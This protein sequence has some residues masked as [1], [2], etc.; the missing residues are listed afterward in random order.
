MISKRFF[1]KSSN[2]K[3]ISFHKTKHQ[4]KLLITIFLQS[5]KN[6]K[7]EK[8]ITIDFNECKK[9]HN[10]FRQKLDFNLIKFAQ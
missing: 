6:K 3:K 9:T 10:F 7:K 8:S 5:Y 1:K 4:N 2:W